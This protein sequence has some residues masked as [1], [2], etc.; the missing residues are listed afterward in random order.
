MGEG[1]QSSRQCSRRWSGLQ[2]HFI[3]LVIG[4]GGSRGSASVVSLVCL[5]SLDVTV[6]MTAVSDLRWGLKAGMRPV[7]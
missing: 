1:S 6:Q 5:L 3:C 7:K 2:R 4:S